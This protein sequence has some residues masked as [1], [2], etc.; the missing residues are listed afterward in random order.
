M[1]LCYVLNVNASAA[2][3]ARALVLGGVNAGY[4]K[5]AGAA[6]TTQRTLTVIIKFDENGLVE[7]FS[8]HS[9]RF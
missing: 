4:G 9:S 7:T 2:V 5:S 1:C 8:Y 3:G 6:A